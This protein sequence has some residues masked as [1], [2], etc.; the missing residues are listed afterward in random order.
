MLQRGV[1]RKRAHL[2]PQHGNCYELPNHGGTRHLR[3]LPVYV[4]RRRQQLLRHSCRHHQMG[5]HN[6]ICSNL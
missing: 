6:R 5:I 1:A 4:H 3:A 2:W